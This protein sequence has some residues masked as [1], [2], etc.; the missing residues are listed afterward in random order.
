MEHTIY[1]LQTEQAVQ[2]EN[3]LAKYRGT[4]AWE[5]TR[6]AFH[7]II[8]TYIHGGVKNMTDGELDEHFERALVTTE[9]DVKTF[10]DKSSAVLNA[11]KN[12]SSPYYMVN[13][14][15]ERHDDYFAVNQTCPVTGM[16]NK[17][18]RLNLKRK[19]YIS[20]ILSMLLPLCLQGLPIAISLTGLLLLLP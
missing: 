10:L 18:W 4:P 17:N 8:R 6:K 15:H 2:I 14:A 9:S 5:T 13:V 20:D 1:K 19:I 16:G 12:T 11:E 3:V 7:E